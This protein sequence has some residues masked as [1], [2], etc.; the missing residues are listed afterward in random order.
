MLS[1]IM[2]KYVQQKDASSAG[3]CSALCPGACAAAGLGNSVR[4]VPCASWRAELMARVCHGA[5]PQ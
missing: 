5:D 3:W 1:G 2:C 4:V